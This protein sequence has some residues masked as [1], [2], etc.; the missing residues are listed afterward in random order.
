MRSVLIDWFELQV[1]AKPDRI[2]E[3]KEHITAA[4]ADEDQVRAGGGGRIEQR[5]HRAGSG[6]ADGFIDVKHEP[7]NVERESGI[8]RTAAAAAVATGPPGQVQKSRI[9]PR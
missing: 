9:Q 8:E 1:S 2:E 5:G 3:H 7:I 6:H 4:S